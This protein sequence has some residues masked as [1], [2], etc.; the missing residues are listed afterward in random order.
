MELNLIHQE[1]LTD[2]TFAQSLPEAIKGKIGSLNQMVEQYNAAPNDDSAVK[3][4]KISAKLW[5]DIKDFEE[6]DRPEETDP[7]ALP[8]D[9]PIAPVPPVD[10]PVPPVPPV[11]PVSLAE[12]RR[13][14]RE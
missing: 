12:R 1:L 9:P 14:Y 3:I 8:I 13:R 4:N 10:P 7:P 2:A 11:E 6:S 5:H